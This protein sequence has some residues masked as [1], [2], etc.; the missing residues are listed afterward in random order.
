LGTSI[1]SSRDYDRVFALES[2]SGFGRVFKQDYHIK[3]ST[4]VEGDFEFG[5]LQEV[6]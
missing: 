1:K 5:D 4:I 3:R 2:L 6:K